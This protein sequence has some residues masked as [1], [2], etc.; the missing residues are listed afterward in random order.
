MAT[1]T[2]TTTTTT[3][4]PN[5]RLESFLAASREA[6][7]APGMPFVDP[8]HHLFDWGATRPRTPEHWTSFGRAGGLFRY[9]REEL[10]RDAAGGGLVATVHVEAHAKDPVA[11]SDMCG[12]VFAA[13]SGAS[14]AKTVGVCRGA[15]ARLD[16][17]R[18]VAELDDAVA[19]HR[20]VLEPHGA[21]LCGIRY[22]VAHHK[23]LMG[24]P[25]AGMLTHA[26]VVRGA[27]RMGELG[28]PVDVWMYHPQLRDLIALA[29]ACPATTFVLDHFGGPVLHP[30]ARPEPTPETTLEVWRENLADLAAKC[31]NVVLKLG[32]M[33][34]EFS[35]GHLRGL[36]SNAESGFS[37]L[38]LANAMEPWVDAARRAFPG[39]V[40]FESNFPMD[41]A[42]VA[43]ATLWN[44]F[45]RLSA[46]WSLAERRDAM[47]GCA[48][49][50][51]ALALP[52]PGLEAF[53][54]DLDGHRQERL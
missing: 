38:G 9:E 28:L 23:G 20:A 32:G 50:V 45:V 22:S 43:Y 24:S 10:V 4:W 53:H 5:D 39:R 11:E 7:L 19:R 2:T 27:R 30:A 26:D 13:S 1:T 36:T 12:R 54:V 29:Q 16:L 33:A 37:S 51:Y 15:V 18:P 21:R 6:W 44:A 34:M 8:H 35:L 41:K 49:R 42:N 48:N 46:A 40:M 14:G 3:A 52:V 25:E 31:P 17:R 47:F